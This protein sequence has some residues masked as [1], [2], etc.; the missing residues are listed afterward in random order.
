MRK[1]QK[2]AVVIIITIILSLLSIMMTG[3][4]KKDSNQRETEYFEYHVYVTGEE[5]W[6][7]IDRLTEKGRQLKNIVIPEEIDGKK[8]TSV[9]GASETPNLKKIIVSYN[10]RRINSWGLTSGS[11]F[12]HG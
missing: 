5:E 7:E 8:V 1:Y 6:V 11:F 3:C 9:R 10:V 12:A 2:K 4:F